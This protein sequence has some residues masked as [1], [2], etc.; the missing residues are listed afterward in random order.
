MPT[1]VTN[2]LVWLLTIPFVFYYAT[3]DLRR[4]PDRTLEHPNSEIEQPAGVWMSAP[5]LPTT[6]YEFGG[7]IVGDTI[8]V[9]GGLPLPTV[10][11]VTGRIRP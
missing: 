3:I 9:L 11:W 2:I 6:R 8:Y 7:D 1:V 10:Y 4:Q 5:V